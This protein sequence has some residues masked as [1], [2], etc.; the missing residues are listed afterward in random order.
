MANLLEHQRHCQCLLYTSR[1]Q[2]G[3][4]Q[5]DQLGLRT[6]MPPRGTFRMVSWNMTRTLN[7][8]A[9][10]LS[11]H[12]C[13]TKQCL[14]MEKL[15]F[16]ITTVSRKARQSVRLSLTPPV[17]RPRTSYD[18]I[19]PSVQWQPYEKSVDIRMGGGGSLIP[20]ITDYCQREMPSTQV[21]SLDKSGVPSSAK[22]AVT[23][24]F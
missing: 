5:D 9:K 10:A 22:E 18:E 15:R 7:G 4:T 13:L 2:S 3:Q 8:H 20:V 6:S 1:Q 14:A 19:V 11:I 12:M 23:F 16:R 21:L 24:T 17:S